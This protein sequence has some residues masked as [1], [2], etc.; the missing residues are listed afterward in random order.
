MDP[1]KHSSGK[2]DPQG[3]DEA[4]ERYFSR[5]NALAALNSDMDSKTPM[6]RAGVTQHRLGDS[7]KYIAHLYANGMPL[8]E[9]KQA[10]QEKSALVQQDTVYLHTVA[11]EVMPYSADMYGVP[12][13]RYV[14][15]FLA[16]TLLLS[17]SSDELL[18]LEQLFPPVDGD[19]LYA[20]DVLV[21]AFIP[22]H[23][24]AKKYKP[25]KW[26]VDW[27]EPFV[28]ALAQ[29]VE[30]RAAA[31]GAYLNN[32][33]RF[34]RSRGWKPRLDTRPGQDELF[35]DFAFEVALAVC[36]WDLDDSSFAAHPY[37]PRDVVEFYRAH[38]RHA[39]DAWRERGRGAG[40]QIVAPPPPK[41]A[42]LAKSKRRA[43]ARWV[44]LACDGDSDAVEAVLDTVGKPKKVKDLG[45]LMEAVAAGPHGIQADIKDDATLE[46]QAV[47]LANARGILVPTDQLPPSGPERCAALLRSLSNAASS[48][49][50]QVFAIDADDDTWLAVLL[51]L[52]YVDE[53]KEL[54]SALGIKVATAEEVWTE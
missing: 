44:E 7:A 4:Y 22:E 46:T 6:A 47:A 26:E 16:L 27:A 41:K 28:R 52:P 13:Q 48:S 50:Y 12:A 18:A 1:L 49:S 21:R 30:T 2:R 32:W 54:S 25:H 45:E 24:L 51:S 43:V 3:S 40:V 34:M 31:L 20:F 9:L 17:E 23:R 5:F 37:Y 33:G 15:P 42:D 19:R 53:F 14:L 38:I 35:A 8:P 10:I 39:R 36:A 29:P 11:V